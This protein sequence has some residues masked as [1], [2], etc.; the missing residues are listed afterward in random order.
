MQGRAATKRAVPAGSQTKLKQDLAKEDRSAKIVHPSDNRSGG[1][2]SAIPGNGNMGL[3]KT[4]TSSTRS[5]THG[6]ETK[7][8]IAGA[9]SFDPRHATGKDDVN[10]S[11][12]VHNQS[13]S[14]GVHSPRQEF[15]KSSD[16]KRAS[17]TEE[18]D[19]LNKRRKGEIDPREIDGGEVRERTTDSR[20]ADK[21]HSP[22]YDKTGSED[23]STNRP[24][25][26]PI[27]RSKEK[28]AER[29][30]R[31]HRER[32]ERPEKSRGDDTL[33]EKQRD[34]S[35]ERHVRERSV[36]KVLERG[37]DRNFDRLGKD[38]RTKDDRSKL[39]YSEVP[40]E[41]S[42]VDD[43]FHNQNLPPPPPLPPHVVPQSIN[44]SKR[45]DDSDRR[46]GSA[47]HGQRL[48]PRHEERERRRSEELLQDDMKR[49]R[50]DD[51]RDRKREERDGLQIKVL[52]LSSV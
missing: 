34:R 23:Q 12:D 18:V 20:A 14:R 36:E 32:L 22:D 33:S 4:A 26:K 44:T 47:R 48:S 46:I 38:E 25:E 45:E 6:N 11:S 42:H 2:T 17:P 7:T 19:R 40:V 5:L 51:F 31:E 9:K 15:S 39:R 8:E 49:R 35:T 50:D 30:E 21:L 41:K 1:V 24:T 37:V 16:R 3:A 13:S 52:F 43:R 28:G 29:H 27:D 10:E